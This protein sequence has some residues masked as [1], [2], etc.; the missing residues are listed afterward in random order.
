M[1]TS[2]H[3]TTKHATIMYTLVRTESRQYIRSMEVIVWIVPGWRLDIS[4]VDYGNIHHWFVHGPGSVSLFRDSPSIEPRSY[5]WTIPIQNRTL[6]FLQVILYR[7]WSVWS[8]IESTW[9]HSFDYLARWV[10]VVVT[11]W[12]PYLSPNASATLGARSVCPS[13]SG[14][15]AINNRSTMKQ[16]VYLGCVYHYLV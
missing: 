13:H 1:R 10:W 16:I 3:C 5:Q 2:L 9:W 8:D 7:Y 11:Y 6:N 14:R 12:R 4:D 15:P